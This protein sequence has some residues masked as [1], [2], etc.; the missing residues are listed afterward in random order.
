[1]PRSLPGSKTTLRWF[2]M[3]QL[4]L[5]AARLLN[6]YTVESLQTSIVLFNP[7]VTSGEKAST[8]T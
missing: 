3:N 8:L 6:L 7:A 2:M 1:M 5:M 4:S